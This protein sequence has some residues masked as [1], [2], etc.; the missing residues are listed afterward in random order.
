MPA[1]AGVLEHSPA[2]LAVEP[3]PGQVI[4]NAERNPPGHG[5]VVQVAARPGGSGSG[6]GASCG[7]PVRPDM[8]LRATPSDV[9]HAK[10]L[11]Y[12]ADDNNNP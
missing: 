9:P 4:G 2:F 6:P 5:R 3:G 1:H 8:G 10:A 12:E 7:L 11:R